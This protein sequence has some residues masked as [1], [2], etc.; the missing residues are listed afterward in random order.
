MWE[1]DAT[2]RAAVEQSMASSTADLG[3]A[4]ALTGVA[5]S[6]EA[7]ANGQRSMYGVAAGGAYARAFEVSL[8]GGGSAPED[9]LGAELATYG[10][11]A[12]S[13]RVD[14]SLEGAGYLATELGARAEDPLV[15]PDPF[16]SGSRLQYAVGGAPGLSAVLSRRSSLH[17]SA[18]YEQEGALDA[19]DPV[20]IGVD[21]HTA[22]AGIAYRREIG[23]RD[24]LRPELEY[25]YAH[26]DHALLDVDLTRGPAD[27]HTGTALLVE[28]HAFSR[29]LVGRVGAGATVA[30]PA[31]LLDAQGVVLTPAALA[32]ITYLGRRYRLAARYTFEHT[33]LGPRIGYGQQ[34]AA[35]AEV[36][37]HPARGGRYRDLVLTGVARLSLGRAPVAADPPLAEY[38]GGPR[39]PL[40][41]VVTAYTALA[42]AQLEVPLAPGLLLLGRFDLR[43]LHATVDPAPTEERSDG[44][45]RT[46]WTVGLA[47]TLSTDRIETVRRAPEDEDDERLESTPAGRR[48][49]RE[50]DRGGA[51]LR[52]D[53]IGPDR[54]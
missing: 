20:A 30:T 12:L 48:G 19:D 49:P 50:P 27:I 53:A 15:A 6:I 2:A 18:G 8:E 21:A 35:R 10:G 13:P 51:P 5:V 17:L 52:D 28:S 37:F 33:S 31:P 14:L 4:S 45:L 29:R 41:G 24:A 54:P 22:R 34:H 40:E 7:V 42:G 1:S 11:W 23:D 3:S 44:A 25:E 26:L 47:G 32:G 36:S 9:S 43:Y 39:D 38:P 46:I 16:L